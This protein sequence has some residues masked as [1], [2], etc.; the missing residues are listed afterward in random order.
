NRDSLKDEKVYKQLNHLNIF[1]NIEL[2]WYNDSS[3]QQN[4]GAILVTN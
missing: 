2:P 3:R 4:T 1:E